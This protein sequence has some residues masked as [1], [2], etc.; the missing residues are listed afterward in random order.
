MIRRTCAAL[1]S[2]VALTMCLATDIFGAPPTVSGPIGAGC[3]AGSFHSLRTPRLSYAVIALRPLT[4]RR[5]RSARTGKRFT[6]KNV[7]GVRTVFAT[8]AQQVDRSCR[9]LQYKVQVPT[10][11]NGSSGWVRAVDVRLISIHTR[12][13]VSLSRRQLILYRDGQPVLVTS[14][15]IGAPSTPTPTGRYYVNQ[16]L[17][18]ANPRGDY[19]PGAVGISAFSPVL[20]SWPQGGPIAIHGTDAPGLVG[21]AISHG[22]LRVRNVDIRVLLRVAEEGTPVEIRP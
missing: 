1:F 11:P 7:N 19:G 21:F 4:V 8:I 2:L 9:A 14:V 5:T 17:L 15:A 22:C 18:A 16:R 6:V 10:R 13:D 3:V 12:I 20:R